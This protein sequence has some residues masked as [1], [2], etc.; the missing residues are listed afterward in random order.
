MKKIPLIVGFCLLVSLSF[1]ACSK[2][3]GGGGGGT[4]TEENLVI[5]VDPNPGSTTAQSL[6]ATYDFRVVISSKVP[7]S[8]VKVD[9]V[10]TRDSDQAVVSSQTLNSSSSPINASVTPLVSGV[11]CTVKVTVT[12]NSKPTNTATLSFKVSRK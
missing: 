12:S 9:V 7:S 6:G 10:C 8:G 1:M 5:N 11:L 3:S 2:K 4:V